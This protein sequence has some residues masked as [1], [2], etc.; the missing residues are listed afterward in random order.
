MI[1]SEGNDK[2][3]SRT[4]TKPRL[5]CTKLDRAPTPPPPPPTRRM[6][7]MTAPSI[8][9]AAA[10]ARGLSITGF[11]FVKVTFNA[12]CSSMMNQS[13]ITTPFVL[14]FGCLARPCTRA[15]MNDSV[16]LNLKAACQ[17]RLTTKAFK[18]LT[19]LLVLKICYL[20]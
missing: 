13:Q 8:C 3:K 12:A 6:R 11:F 15:A 9:A 7:P 2:P 5:D 10:G 14:A 19:R 16:M 1:F 20:Y 17:L 18:N 4:E